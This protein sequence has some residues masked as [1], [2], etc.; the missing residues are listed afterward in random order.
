MPGGDE[1]GE[2]LVY[3]WGTYLVTVGFVQTAQNGRTR[4]ARYSP[5]RVVR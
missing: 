4:P 1:I 5:D 3:D 2:L